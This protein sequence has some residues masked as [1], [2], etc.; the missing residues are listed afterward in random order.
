[1]KSNENFDIEVYKSGSDGQITS[2]G[3]INTDATDS[4]TLEVKL[5]PIFWLIV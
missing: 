5:I 3:F 1:M 2:L 4:Q